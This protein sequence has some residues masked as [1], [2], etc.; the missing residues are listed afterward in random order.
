M[1]QQGCPLALY[2]M[3]FG[4]Y[5]QVNFVEKKYSVNHSRSRKNKGHVFTVSPFLLQ[6]TV[7]QKVISIKC[8]SCITLIFGN[9]GGSSWKDRAI[10]PGLIPNV[11]HAK[12]V[13]AP[14]LR[15]LPWES[16]T[17]LLG[18]WTM[19]TR[20]GRKCMIDH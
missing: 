11:H 9:L 18:R 15:N 19:S 2:L 4:F 6:S 17:K 13:L 14:N 16:D 20:R 12:E 1:I 5:N 3:Y 8:T 10:P 7:T